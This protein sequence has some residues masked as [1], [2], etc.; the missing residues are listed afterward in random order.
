MELDVEY[1]DNWS[2]REDMKLLL[3]TI[4]AVFSGRGAY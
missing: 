2:F 1:I 4:P 3:L